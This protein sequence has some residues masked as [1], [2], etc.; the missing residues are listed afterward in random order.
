[1]KTV[2]GVYENGEIKLLEKSPVTGTKKVLVTFFDTDEDEEEIR[3]S[4][5]NKLSIS[6][7]EYLNDEREDLYQEYLK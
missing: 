4:T 5:L 7:K 6:F 2:K 1:M 3:S